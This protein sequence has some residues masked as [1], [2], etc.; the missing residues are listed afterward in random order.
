M[1]KKFTLEQVD[2]FFFFGLVLPVDV[3]WRT[4]NRAKLVFQVIL[5]FYVPVF[6]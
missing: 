4:Q 2:F 3:S 5:S 6:S 1:L